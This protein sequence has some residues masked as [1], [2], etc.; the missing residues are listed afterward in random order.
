MIVGGVLRGR[1]VRRPWAEVRF[2]L[3][4]MQIPVREIKRIRRELVELGRSVV[5]VG[6]EVVG[7]LKRRSEASERK[8]AATIPPSLLLGC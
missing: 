4:V 6:G 5:F 7:V 1:L 8:L 2:G 3:R